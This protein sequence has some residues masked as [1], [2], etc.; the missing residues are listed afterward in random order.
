MPYELIQLAQLAFALSLMFGAFLAG[1]GLGWWKWGRPAQRAQQTE[2]ATTLLPR[3]SPELFTPVQVDP[4]EV[5]LEHQLFDI[6]AT[7]HPG[8]HLHRP[9]RELNAPAEPL[10]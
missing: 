7:A 2:R 10:A 3:V 5:V 1:L 6:T 4:D 9:A 8:Q